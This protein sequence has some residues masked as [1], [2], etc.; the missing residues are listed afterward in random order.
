MLEDITKV[1]RIKSMVFIGSNQL[2]KHSEKMVQHKWNKEVAKAKLNAMKVLSQ[3][4]VQELI[5]AH[6]ACEDGEDD[7]D[8]I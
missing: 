6:D 8:G 2:P 7:N 4:M 5:A 1:A 3:S